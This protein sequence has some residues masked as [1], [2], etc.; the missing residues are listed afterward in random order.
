[1]VWLILLVMKV[2]R[3]VARALQ[4]SGAIAILLELW[5]EPDNQ[6]FAP[7]I[8]T[9]AIGFVDKAAARRWVRQLENEIDR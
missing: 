1:M 4:D 3:R 2:H 9:I 6:T 7:G 5:E 8:K